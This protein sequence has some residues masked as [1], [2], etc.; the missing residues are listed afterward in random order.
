M[1]SLTSTTQVNLRAFE[2]KTHRILKEM[3]GERIWL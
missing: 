2:R 3:A 1:L